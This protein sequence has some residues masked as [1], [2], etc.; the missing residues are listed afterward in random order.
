[1]A[2]IKVEKT[3]HQHIQEMRLEMSK[4]TLNKTGYNKHLNYKYYELGDFLPQAHE[5]LVKH[6]LCPVY[7]ISTAPNGIET[8]Y[9]KVMKGME[10]VVFQIP[11]SDVPNM[12]GVFNLGAKDTYCLRYLMARHLFMLSDADVSEANNTDSNAKVEVR[13]ATEKQIEMIKGLYDE[14]NIT[15]I[16]EY[17]KTDKLEDLSLKDASAVIAKKR[18]K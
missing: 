5:L 16:L 1:M 9:L 2:E 14:E 12:N 15:K 3:I 4:M 13:K 6:G 18:G 10:N 8:A 7:E 17:F 11:T